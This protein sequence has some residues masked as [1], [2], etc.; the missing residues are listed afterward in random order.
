MLMNNDNDGLLE[1]SSAGTVNS[2]IARIFGQDTVAESTATTATLAMGGSVTGYINSTTDEDWY[3]V[4]LSAGLTYSFA[5]NGTNTNGNGALSDPLIRLYNSAGSQVTFNDDGGP[6]LNS[7]LNFTP[8]TTGTYYIAAD[9][10]STQTGEYTMSV[11]GPSP[12]DS[13]DWGTTAVAPGATIN[14]YFAGNGE[15]FDGVTSLGWSA[16]EIQ[17]AMAAF[18]LY[19]NVLNVSFNQVGSAAGSNFQLVTTNNVSYLG[20]FN[21]PGTT[22][23]GVGVFANDGTGWNNTGGLAQGGYGFITF[24]HEFGHAMGLAHP[25]DGGGTSS[26][27]A[28]VTSSTG[29]Y[30]DYNLNQG[31][32]TTMTYNDG[33]ATGPLGAVPSLNY[34]YQGALMALDIASLQADYGANTSTNSG[35]T[36]YFLPTT[37]AGGTFYSAIWDTG[38]IDSIVGTGSV[39]VTIDLRP[40]S[41][42][43]ATGGGGYVSYVAGI[44]GGYTIAN[45]VVIENAFGSSANDTIRGNEAGNTLVAG[46]GNDTIYGYGGNDWLYGQAGNDTIYAGAGAVDVSIGDTGIDTIY[47]QD[48]FDYIY[49]YAGNDVLWGGNDVDVIYGGSGLDSLYGQSGTDWLFGGDSTDYMYGG[50]NPDLMI[51]EGGGDY[52]VAGT[53]NDW[54]WGD[55]TNGLGGGGADRFVFTD[56]WGGD[57]I[58]DFENGIDKID[59]SGSSATG[60]SDLVIGQISGGFTWVAYGADVIYLWGAGN[61]NVGVGNI[62]ASDFIFV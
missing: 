14:V 24:I 56:G 15:T 61:M 6:G 52:I 25:H 3:A 57:V 26:V 59:L 35:G 40:A 4:E 9:A 30:G 11:N 51:G 28:G 13:I 20:Y 17:Q 39:S 19:Q 21:P 37:N 55:S 36:N 53:G 23:A 58:Y 42:Q 46:A 18:G 44:Y 32:F 2:E 1:F 60:F 62:D 49:G 27:M 8:G 5:L 43:Y 34:G 50:A 47:G 38:G 12:L 7:L 33:W 41:L 10:F 16:Y 45:G 29:D 48:G 22:N 31:V 54:I